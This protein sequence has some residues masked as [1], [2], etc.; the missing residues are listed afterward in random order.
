MEKFGEGGS[1]ILHV[2]DDDDDDVF[3]CGDWLGRIVLSFSDNPAD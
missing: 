2:S 1:D 3:V